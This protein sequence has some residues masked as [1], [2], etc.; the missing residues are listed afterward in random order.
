MIKTQRGDCHIEGTTTEILAD[1][2][3][4]LAAIGHKL[5]YELEIDQETII[6]ALSEVTAMAIKSIDE[7]DDVKE[8]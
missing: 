3:C 6:G 1:A 7:V 5:R 4:V 8:V 2:T